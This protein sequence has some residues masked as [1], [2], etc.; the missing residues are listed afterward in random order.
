[1]GAGILAVWIPMPWDNK[2][3]KM[4]IMAKGCSNVH[5][6]PNAACLYLTL[7]SFQVKK[8]NNSRYCQSSFQPKV[9]TDL[10]FMII[11]VDNV[12]MCLLVQRYG[13]LLVFNVKLNCHLSKS[14]CPVSGRDFGQL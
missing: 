9:N 3:T 5:T 10:G 7:I 6:I 13:F 4:V 8:Y 14:I 1:M 11:S 2:S 12:G